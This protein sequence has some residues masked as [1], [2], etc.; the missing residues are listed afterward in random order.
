MWVWALGG[1]LGIILRLI[2]CFLQLR[3]LDT[4][5]KIKF[6]GASMDGLLNH[7]GHELVIAAYGSLLTENVTIECLDC[8]EVLYEERMERRNG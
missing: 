3:I 5:A 6:G 7:R 8:N 4:G 2:Y 1:I